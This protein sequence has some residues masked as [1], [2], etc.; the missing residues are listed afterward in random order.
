MTTKNGKKR[1]PSLYGKV[2]AVFRSRRII[3]LSRE[4]VCGFKRLIEL[5]TW[6][7]LG[8]LGMSDA[9]RILRMGE[10]VPKVRSIFHWT[11]RNMESKG[12]PVYRGPDEG[13][14]EWISLDPDYRHSTVADTKRT[15]RRM[16]SAITSGIAHLE[17]SDR[18]SL[19]AVQ[20]QL[21]ALGDKRLV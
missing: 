16:S 9:D 17:K 7:L 2:E 8:D 13:L 18:K 1:K 19:P 15:T 3:S 21:S 4:N 20:K 5:V 11:L 12:T 14:L 6:H 10:M